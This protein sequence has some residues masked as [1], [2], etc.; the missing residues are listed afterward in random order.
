MRGWPRGSPGTRRIG[1]TRVPALSVDVRDRA[2]ERLADP[3]APGRGW[4]A[5]A[6][7]SDAPGAG[8]TEGTYPGRAG[9]EA[10][11]RDRRRLVP[12]ATARR[13]PPGRSPR[14]DQAE[15]AE[16][17]RDGEYLTGIQAGRRGH[18][19]PTLI[20]G[21]GGKCGRNRRTSA[22]G[23]RRH[24]HTCV[25][26]LEGWDQDQRACCTA[27]PSFSVRVARCRDALP[28]GCTS[29]TVTGRLADD[30]DVVDGDVRP[31]VPA[32]QL[33]RP[34]SGRRPCGVDRAVLIARS[35]AV[36]SWVS[37]S[38]AATPSDPTPP[39]RRRRARRAGARYR[40]GRSP[41][42][43]SVTARSSTIF[44]G[45]WR[46]PV[47]PARQCA[48]QSPPSP[49]ARMVSVSSSPPTGLR[50]HIRPGPVHG[51][52][53]AEPTTLAHLEGAPELARTAQGHFSAVQHTFGSIN[54][55]SPGASAGTR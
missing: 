4:R 7:A 31:G 45:S 54:D 52:A 35:A 23:S 24:N 21:S 1:R 17:S 25:D 44:A 3:E 11:G 10:R 29:R 30:G 43:P 2:H 37:R 48:R 16:P 47:P 55:E 13:A 19:S 46:V 36:V 28:G 34:G 33:P 42:S 27:P 18:F 53:R 50:H 12:R 38:I 51:R 39:G 6:G 8:Q 15:V 14:S 32:G 26:Q 41:R 22:V 9:R 20:M 40:R 49:T 5:H